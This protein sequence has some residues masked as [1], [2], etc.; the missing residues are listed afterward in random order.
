MVNLLPD[1]KEMFYQAIHKLDELIS[2]R[3]GLASIFTAE[4]IR[5]WVLA[6]ENAFYIDFFTDKTPNIPAGINESSL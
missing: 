4:I 6:L 1:V 2:I 5:K 3:I